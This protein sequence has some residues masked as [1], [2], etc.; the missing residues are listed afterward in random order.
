MSNI[1]EQVI[2]NIKQAVRDTGQFDVL[3][4]KDE[5]TAIA[6]Q[7][8]DSHLVEDYE[9]AILLY[10]DALDIYPN[11]KPA[12]YNRVLA[13]MHIKDYDNALSDIEY[14]VR[15]LPPNIAYLIM[16]GEVYMRMEHYKSA[17]ADFTYVINHPQQV[18]KWRAYYLR[19]ACSEHVKLSQAI[20]DFTYL[21]QLNQKPEM[22]YDLYTRRAYIYELLGD[23]ESAL[24]DYLEAIIQRHEYPNAYYGLARVYVH[25]RD[26][27]KALEVCEQAIKLSSDNLDYQLYR[28]S[29]LTHLQRYSD[30]IQE[31][32]NILKVDI[33]NL[34]ALNGLAF[35]YP[36]VDEL[37]EALH[38]A[39]KAIEHHEPTASVF[40][41]RA[42]IHWLMGNYEKA[43]QDFEIVVEL[44]NLGIGVMGQAITQLALGNSSIAIDLWHEA[45]KLDDA[46]EDIEWL[47]TGYRYAPKYVDAGRELAKLVYR[48]NNE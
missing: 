2:H 17:I 40:D 44:E 42:Q 22:L 30:A 31:Y 21:I 15:S 26:F 1:F 9:K 28:A 38:Y 35:F 13:Y 7:A 3:F 43:L 14:L 25:K 41:T 48:D 47:E 29:I 32:K 11:H 8:Y 19:A 24:A 34:E 27:D 37:E 10:S 5:A 39:T 46:L 23:M 18:N 12:R 33:K 36:H 6:Y 20:Y 16:R 45:V 4:V